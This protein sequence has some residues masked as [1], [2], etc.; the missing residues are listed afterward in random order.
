[1][2]LSNVPGRRMLIDVDRPP[3][4]ELVA[5]AA[6]SQGGH[7]RRGFHGPQPGTVDFIDPKRRPALVPGAADEGVDLPVAKRPKNT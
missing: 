5:D 4:R 7:R 6:Q 3:P 1:M 2:S